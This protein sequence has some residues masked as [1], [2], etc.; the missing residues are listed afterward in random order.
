MK[1]NLIIGASS[2]IGLAL[3][4][5]L[6]AKGE[7]VIALSRTVPAI[8]NIEHHFYDAVS[9]DALPDLQTAIDSIVYCPGSINLRPFRA[10]KPADFLQ[11]LQLNVMGAINC[12]QKYYSNLSASEN[13]SILMFSTVAVQT[14]MP[15]HA[16]IAVSKGAIEGLT[17][18]LAAEFAPK[19]RVNCIA[20]SLTNTPLADKLINTQA[21]LD[22]AALRHPLKK[23]G[24]PEQV[25]AMAAFLLSAEASF[26]TGQI[27][28]ID[29]GMSAVRL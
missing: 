25:A 13:A 21:K 15:F 5:Q 23:I 20:P 22:V 8:D 26:I 10:L 12:I 7:K 28:H 2:G 16:S 9:T 14:G 24:D 29:G 4:K 18:S 11:E 27:I 3:A 6:I 17:R 19:V 1:T